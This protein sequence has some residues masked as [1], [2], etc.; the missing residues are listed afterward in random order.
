MI[1]NHQ[2]T[3]EILKWFEQ[4]NQFPRCSKNEGAVRNWL[5]DW[6]K[7]NNFFFKTDNAQN[8]LIKVPASPSYEN[9]PIVV[10]QG[11]LDMVCEKTPDSNHDFTT[12]PIKLIQEGEWIT[13]DQTTLGA[14]NG[15][16]IAIAM[17]LALNKEAPHPPLELLF[18][19]DEE[20]G[21]N[22]ANALEPDLL[23]GRILINLDADDEG[24]FIIGCA[25]GIS[26]HLS[27]PVEWDDVSTHY[28]LMEIKTGGMTGGHSG[29]DIHTE[30][31]NAIKILAQALYFIKTQIDIR[32][33]K[34]NGGTAH[35]AIPRDADALVWVPQ[36][37]TET[38]TKLVSEIEIR[39]KS[40]YKNT[41]PDLFIKMD[42][43][44]EICEQATT[45]ES[46]SK[47]IDVLIVV[48][49]GVTAMSTEME[50]LVETSTNFAGVSI[51]AGKLKIDTSQRSSVLSRRDA[52]AH[53]I[54]AIARLAGGEAYK[55]TF[56]PPWT[57]KT[58][59][60]LLTKS[61]QVY[62]KLF[63]DKK[64]LVKVMHA[65]LECGVIGDKVSGMDM[66]SMGPTIRSP[67]SPHERIHIGSIGRFW[68][69]FQELLKEL[70]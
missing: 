23:A 9:A 44:H 2:K 55:G 34:L 42:A 25:G 36:N 37:H 56:Y 13:A 21:L 61:V 43:S 5:I 7:E 6:A 8:L 35:N 69:F 4:I 66:I 39:L 46:T 48:P 19:V 15:I 50:N 20:T 54:E 64:P 49:H 29:V 12:D 41:D 45:S 65:G 52:L 63:D 38:V 58:N 33:A 70:K 14:D 32:L 1:C 24:C 11:H 31:A 68:D 3:Q 16:A 59:S 26:T 47:I 10:L 53:R 18:T 51:N 22:G 57:P 62:E 60:S 40:E 27:I 30:K 28:Q 67:H 17:T